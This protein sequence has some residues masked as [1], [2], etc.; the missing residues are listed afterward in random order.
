MNNILLLLSGN[1]IPFIPAQIAIHQPTIREIAYI[2]EEAFYTG[3]ELI[4]F[5]KNRLTEEDKINLED[6]SDFDILI[7]ILRER[8]AVMQINRNCV[9]MVLALVFPEYHISIKRDAIILSKEGEENHLINRDNFDDFKRIFN[10]MFCLKAEDLKSYNPKG[11]L[12][13]KLAEKFKKRQ[14]KLAELKKDSETKV[15]N[16]LGRY[17]SILAVG[18]HQDIN[19]LMNYTVYQINDEFER[20]QLKASNDIY[21]KAKM[22]GA[23][24]LKEVEDWMKEIHSE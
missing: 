10:A 3:C 7:A 8:K 9:E 24:D 13:N 5:S 19:S 20:Y 15:I 17:A 22:A 11:T 18:N 6:K 23:K 21:I 1:D 14:Q 4:N 16:I 12:A 2:G